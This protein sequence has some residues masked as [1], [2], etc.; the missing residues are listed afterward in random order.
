MN[1]PEYYKPSNKFS[2]VGLVLMFISMIAVGVIVSWLYLIINSVIPLIYL[3]IL[4]AAGVSA[5]IGFIGG[6]FI[7]IFKI[8][9]PMAAI[10]VAV[11]ALL[12]VNYV[13]W[14]IY[15][16]RD[17][18]KYVYDDMKDYTLSE[19]SS[20]I[21]PIPAMYAYMIT[22]STEM[23][24][25]EAADAIYNVEED[26][27][28]LMQEPLNKIEDLAKEQGYDTSTM[29][30]EQ[31][32]YFDSGITFWELLELDI[33]LGRDVDEIVESSKEL[34]NA[35]DDTNTYEWVKEHGHR[36]TVGYL[37]SHPS[38]LFRSVKTIN[39][40]GRWSIKSH[41]Y[42][43][44]NDSNSSL[45]KG[46]MLW[47][48]WFGELLML[49][50]PALM[51][52][53]ES[54]QKPFIE[55][56]D[57]WAIV[58][59]PAPEFKFVDPYPTQSNSPATAASSFTRDPDYLFSLEPLTSLMAVPDRFFFL[60]YCRSKYYDEIYA[61][62]TCSTL[63]NKA[64]NQRQNSVLVKDL[65]VDANFLATMF[66]RFH[67]Q[68]PPLCQGEN[69]AEEIEKETKARAMAEA[70]GKPLAPQRPK[71]TGAEAI[72]D[73]PP[74]TA[75]P[76][77]ETEEDFARRQMEEERRKAE[78]EHKMQPVDV[79]K[80]PKV[81]APPVQSYTPP[82]GTPGGSGLMDGIDTSN[83]DLSN[84]DFK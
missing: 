28:K 24:P 81:E 31:R 20:Q 73:E 58:D 40:V 15:V 36:K 80:A 22:N 84:F 46:W 12:C 29:T 37:L 2:P 70:S 78:A 71:A 39:A 30:A 17:N 25:E 51:M 38:E 26:G 18:D 72:F 48:V 42:S 61:T 64:K 4:L 83:L 55:A 16:D 14:A 5:A 13:K 47:I 67:Y 49:T 63:T 79:P 69:R 34:A 44:L 45:V 82:A 53:R 10:I 21:N 56:E 54:A 27:V 43:S 74:I 1:N 68:V 33:F 62:L 50:I 8:R 35:G 3:N 11:A 65:R 23:S 75:K 77:V 66:G 57:D 19:Y 6:R 52:I 59:K 9:N 76:K 60:T 7:K 32:A 41:R